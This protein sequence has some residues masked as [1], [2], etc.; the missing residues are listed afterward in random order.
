M[1]FKESIIR[2]ISPTEDEVFTFG[3]AYGLYQKGGASE[4]CDAVNDGRIRHDGWRYCEPCE[5]NYPYL[6]D[7]CLVC[8]N[9]S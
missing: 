9:N 2:I 5:S 1:G 3:V 7:T 6:T 4:V 8:G